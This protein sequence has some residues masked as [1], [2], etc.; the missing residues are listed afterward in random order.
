MSK[1]SYS[2][3]FKD[4]RSCFSKF[5]FLFHLKDHHIKDI[6]FKF[7]LN[8]SS[9]L[10]V[11]NYFV[12]HSFLLCKLNYGNHKTRHIFINIFQVEPF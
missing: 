2:S 6:N 4:A 5:S 9:R 11:G 8:R 7:Q 10:D 1:I 3:K 12:D